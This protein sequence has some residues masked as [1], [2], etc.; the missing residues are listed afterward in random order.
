M[1]EKI[2]Q[3]VVLVKVIKRDSRVTQYNENRVKSCIKKAMNSCGKHSMDVDTL[4]KNVSSIL[5]LHLVDDKVTSAQVDEAIIQQLLDND[6][7]DVAEAYNIYKEHRAIERESETDI[8]HHVYKLYSKDKAVINE[9][10]NKDSR[11]FPTK[12]DLLAGAVSKPV[13]LKL[14]P[15]RVRT[16]HLNGEIH[17]H[18]LDFSP[19]ETYTN[20]C[21]VDLKGMLANGFSMGNA[22]VTSPNSIQTATAQ[23][24]QIVANV[25]SCQMGGISLDRLD[26]VLAPYA[27]K[28]YH[29]HLKIGEKYGI[30]NLETYAKNQTKKDIYD[31]MQSLEYEVNTLYVSNGQS[32]FT[33]IGFGL[34]TSW[35]EK[36]I[37]SAI[38][39]VRYDGIGKQKKTA[40]FP[41]LLFTIKKGINFYP[42]DPN[43]DIKQ[44]ALICAQ[45]RVY[46]DIL[47]YDKIVELTGSFKASMGK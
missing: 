36:E 23:T 42:S 20:C 12:R 29:K 14:L 18:D 4:V 24:A 10:A 34:G 6:L 1:N 44:K 25:A 27:E 40:I 5:K 41:K 9:N 26:E 30:T 43:Y 22:E 38:L 11:T 35:I 13:G 31:A 33:T 8:T 46:P 32:P 39:Q 37:Q 45:K 21:L 28:N 19:A 7:T 15:K 2:I 47:N 17:F 16:A 3:G